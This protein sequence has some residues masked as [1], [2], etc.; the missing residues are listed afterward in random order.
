MH[1]VSRR[2]LTHDFSIW[3]GLNLNIHTG[4]TWKTDIGLLKFNALSI[5]QQN[6]LIRDGGFNCLAETF[7]MLAWLRLAAQCSSLTICILKSF[8]LIVK[9]PLVQ[10]RRTCIA[11]HMMFNKKCYVDGVPHVSMD[12]EQQSN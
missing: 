9:S 6:Y 4:T 10:T 3:K 5:W 11:T 1:K 7:T 2:Q 12:I 8:Q